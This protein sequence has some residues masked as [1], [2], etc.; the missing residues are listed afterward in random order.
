MR[1][2]SPKMLVFPSLGSQAE[3]AQNRPRYSECPWNT[4]MYPETRERSTYF[5]HLYG[6]LLSTIL[7]PPPTQFHRG[8]FDLF[9]PTPERRCRDSLRRQTAPQPL[10]GLP[11][12][13]PPRP[14]ALHIRIKSQTLHS[15]NRSHRQQVPNLFPLKP[16]QDDVRRQHINITRRVSL[17]PL[18]ARR[19]NRLHIISPPIQ[20]PRSLHLHPQ[21]PPPRS[22]PHN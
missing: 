5:T 11:I 12:P 6:P 15:H 1:N 17:L 13:L 9:C 19:V 4:I 22:R 18:P 3:A 20:P 8:D 7:I 2:R 21:Q 16:L 14:P 10:P